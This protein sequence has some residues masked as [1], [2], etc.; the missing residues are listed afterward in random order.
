MDLMDISYIDVNELGV[1]PLN[2]TGDENELDFDD[3]TNG[4]FG[5][6]KLNELQ[7]TNNGKKLAIDEEDNSMSDDDD[8]NYEIDPETGKFIFFS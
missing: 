4:Y 2:W 1:R 8:E 3:I 7:I 5:K 6:E